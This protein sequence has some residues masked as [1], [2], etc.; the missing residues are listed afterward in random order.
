MNIIN[1][2]YNEYNIISKLDLN[3]EQT[4]SFAIQ[5]YYI[6]DNIVSDIVNMKFF[7]E[8]FCYIFI[9]DTNFKIHCLN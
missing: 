9:T 6:L 4:V 1:I 3:N 8:H 2:N 5:I 7:Q